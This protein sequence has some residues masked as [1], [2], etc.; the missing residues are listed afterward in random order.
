MPSSMFQYKSAEEMV[1]FPSTYSFKGSPHPQCLGVP[2]PVVA[3]HNT[4]CS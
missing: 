2:I 4:L 3:E 1:L